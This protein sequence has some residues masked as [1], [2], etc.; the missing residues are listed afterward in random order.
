MFTMFSIQDYEDAK[1]KPVTRCRMSRDSVRM[2]AMRSSLREAFVAEW[3]EALESDWGWI[4]FEHGGEYGLIR[5]SAV[6]DWIRL[7]TK[8]MAE[9]RK[10]LKRGDRSVLDEMLEHLKREIPDD[11]DTDSDN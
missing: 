6:E 2:L 4:A 8:R 5:A 7:G 11:G 9:R 3:A 10:R 1:G